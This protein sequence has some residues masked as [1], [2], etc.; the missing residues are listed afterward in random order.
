MNFGSQFGRISYTTHLLFYPSAFIL[1]VFAYK[2]YAKCKAKA[3]SEKEWNEMPALRKVDKDIFNPFTPI[4]FHNNREL[5]YA[6]AH[7]NMQGYVNTVKPFVQA[8]LC[9][10][11]PREMEEILVVELFL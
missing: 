6:F 5:K 1:Y 7:I 3:Q 8:P 4:P 9:L 11:P 2:P 10:S